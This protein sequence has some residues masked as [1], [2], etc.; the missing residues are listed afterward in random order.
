M[1]VLEL[2]SKYSALLKILA[3]GA[4]GLF[5]FYKV[6]SYL[7]EKQ[8]LQIEKDRLQKE[9]MLTKEQLRNTVATANE[10]A[11]LLDKLHNDNRLTLEELQSKHEED[12]KKKTTYTIIREKT[13]YEKDSDF[14][15]P[16]LRNTIDRLYSKTTGTGN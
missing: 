11:R 8:E 14:I 13:K 5:L 2:F 3:I 7:V 15:S 1:I 4:L 16:V 12:M 10:N 9:L 6:N